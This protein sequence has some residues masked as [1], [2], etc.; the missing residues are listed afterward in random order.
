MP[1]PENRRMPLSCEPCRERKIRCPRSAN[2]PRGPCETCIRRG[3]PPEDCVYLRDLY[4]RRPTLAAAAAQASAHAQCSLQ[5]DNAR[6]LARINDLEELVR[7]Q[8]GA[9]VAV[10][11][12]S[13]K[14]RNDASHL[15]SPDSTMH[16][17][18]R[19]AQDSDS[20]GM[21]LGDDCSPPA[22]TPPSSALSSV[23]T[24]L[25]FESGHERYE[26][27]SSKWSSILGDGPVTRGIPRDLDRLQTP[28]DFAFTTMKADVQD[29]LS[30]LP[31][32]SYCDELKNVYFGTFATL[33][34]VLHDPT[35]DAEYTE[36]RDDPLQTPLPWLALLYAILGVAV[37]AV[38]EDS[39]FLWDL[40]RQQ[41]AAENMGLLTSRYRA[42]AMKCLEADHY[43]W[44]HNLHTL[45]AL[46]ILIYGINHTHGQSW[47][48]LGTARNIAFA[49]GCH[50]DPDAFSL[51]LVVAEQ[52]RR[53]WAALNMLYTIQNTTL[54]YLDTIQ[55]PFS[56]KLPLDVDDYQ[57]T[58]GVNGSA[59]SR[60]GPPS[61]VSY[62][63]F[64]FKL[65]DIASRI[66]SSLFRHGHRPSYDTILSLDAE[67]GTQQ[68]AVNNKYLLDTTTA[69]LP[70]YHAVHLNI[71]FGYTHQLT[72]LLHRPVVMQQQALS[73]SPIN[74]ATVGPYTRAQITKSQAKCV[75]SSRAL[76]G[77]HRVLHENE[78][79]RTYRW[80]NRGI[81][82]FHAFHAAVFL[83]Y[84]CY[85]CCVSDPGDVED[86]TITAL[87]RELRDALRMF[88]DMARD[89]LS[90]ICQKATPVLRKL[91]EAAAE[92]EQG[93]Y[94]HPHSQPAPPPAPQSAENGLDLL[95][96]A[97]GLDPQQWLS[98]SLMDW[99]D[100]NSL[101]EASEVSGTSQLLQ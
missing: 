20:T 2:R 69:A 62:L 53:C 74:V 87:I 81:G 41:T 18:P 68:H 46:V 50:V 35:F 85:V 70:D 29:L 25:H 76:L 88:S 22:V 92:R 17:P 82:S 9:A 94:Y 67:I 60:S 95:L 80:Y 23:G 21:T 6:L 24:L 28:P 100:W 89:G 5:A 90:P 33:F 8:L 63:L 31:P 58:T 97:E 36:F 99:N 64:K 54:G 12:Q 56:V 86:S 84:Y 13:P 93:R 26:P 51:D 42:W 78:A 55:P 40:G 32:S 96:L 65:Y 4:P 75:E 37:T 59:P 98:P 19:S 27:L 7:A 101:V 15:P 91:V 39:A 72:L 34:H 1:A 44:R 83:A 10:P 73:R 38:P 48:L 61:K 11:Q 43:L 30:M 52:R 71:L 79:Y 16:C 57:L 47:A 3:I 49:L 45:Q 77:I 66:C 14:L